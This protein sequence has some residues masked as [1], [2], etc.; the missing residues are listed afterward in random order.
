M[1]NG[2]PF[3]SRKLVT[4]VMS[5]SQHRKNTS[6]LKRYGQNRQREQGGLGMKI[7]INLE[8]HCSFKKG[9]SNS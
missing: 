6:Q 1:L 4:L 9:E 5:S 7:R 8:F 3:S 2:I